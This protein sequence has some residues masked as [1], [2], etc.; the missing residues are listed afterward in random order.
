M[1][2]SRLTPV[3]TFLELADLNGWKVLKKTRSTIVV[4]SPRTGFMEPRLVRVTPDGKNLAFGENGQ[5][6]VTTT[7]NEDSG[8]RE[9]AISGGGAARVVKNTFHPLRSAPWFAL[10][11]GKND[12]EL[13][14]PK[15]IQHARLRPPRIRGYFRFY[16]ADELTYK[17]LDKHPA[18]VWGLDAWVEAT[19]GGPEGKGWN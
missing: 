18:E 9:Y 13:C 11:D 1:T 14:D 12:R 7:I 19:L 17:L 6:G 16:D 15:Q 4:E 10:T 8:E 2:V 5:H 3:K